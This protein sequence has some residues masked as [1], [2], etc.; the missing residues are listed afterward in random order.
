MP[1]RGLRAKTEAQTA[2]ASRGPP[3]CDRGAELAASAW[4]GARRGLAGNT[5]LEPA[6]AWPGA[7]PLP[8]PH[9]VSQGAFPSAHIA[10]SARLSRSVS[11][12]CQ[13]SSCW[14]AISSPSAASRSIGPFSKTVSSSSM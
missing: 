1:S 11:I 2:P 7:L 4:P 5:I 10:S 9:L 8:P 14:K 13:K 12:E 3:S 6:K